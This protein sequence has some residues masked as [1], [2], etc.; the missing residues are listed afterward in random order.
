MDESPSAASD[1]QQRLSRLAQPAG[2]SKEGGYQVAPA[3]PTDRFIFHEDG[4]SQWR[5][6]IYLSEAMWPLADRE[7]ALL[8]RHYVQKLAIWVRFTLQARVVPRLSY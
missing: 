1:H 7:E 5:S 4:L 6:Q 8:F 2:P 3:S